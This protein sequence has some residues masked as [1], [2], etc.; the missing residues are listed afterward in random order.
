MLT[1][2]F[3]K[4]Y[5]LHRS[6][7][8]LGSVLDDFDDWLVEHGYRHATRECYVLRCTAIERYLQRRKQRSISE[9]TPEKLYE[10]WRFFRHRPGGI[11]N[12]VTCLERFLLSRHLL[13]ERCL[14]TTPFSAILDSY[15][16]HLT[17]V[18]GLATSTIDQHCSTTSEFLQHARER[19]RAF[20]P[21][22]LTQTHVEAFVNSVHRRFNRPSLQHVIAHVRGFIRFLGVQGDVPAGLDLRI[23]TPR[24]YRLE[25]LPHSLPWDTVRAFLD[26]IDR[27][28]ASG[29]RDYAMFMLI[30][31][32]GLR[33][34]DIASL[35]LTDISWRAGEVHSNQSK[36]RHPLQ[37]PLTDSVADALIAYLRD[38]RPQSA[39]RKLFLSVHAPILPIRRQSAGYA[40]RF[41]VARSGL[42]I[43]F[44]GVHCLRH[45]YAT[46]LLRQGVSLKSIGDLLGHLSTE[47]TC[48]Y[49]RLDLDDLRDV[50]LPLPSAPGREVQA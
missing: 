37:L 28:R 47:S 43:P 46:H 27:T 25:Q 2:L 21:Q 49:L 6:L 11:S 22:D 13:P 12:A 48:V 35:E 33:G 18:R 45:S 4:S 32:Y 1:D 42:D 31:T 50:A 29:L 17:E 16:V 8:L 14:P 5:E 7:P 15:R 3:P 36:T 9:L 44:R 23:D 26:S 30:A 20:R 34:C 39:H 10:C 38:G 41:R 19:D 24:V 40:F